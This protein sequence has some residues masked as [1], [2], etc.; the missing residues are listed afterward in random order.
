MAGIGGFTTTFDILQTYEP[1]TSEISFRVPAIPEGLQFADYFDTYAGRLST[2]GDWSKAQSL[3]C[4][5]P[6]T[7]P[8]AG[9]YLTVDDTLPTP[10]SGKGYYYVTDVNYQGERRYGRKYMGGQLTGRD[11]ALLPECT[12]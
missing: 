7:A 1:T 6:A 5:Y 4:G 3:Q 9:D 2:V 8:A 11:P 10:P 12:E